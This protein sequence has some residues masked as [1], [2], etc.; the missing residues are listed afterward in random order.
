MFLFLLGGRHLGQI[1]WKNNKIGLN[2]YLLEEGIDY[3]SKVK[4]FNAKHFNKLTNNNQQWYIYSFYFVPCS[5]PQTDHFKWHLI[6]ACIVI[7]I[8]WLE[9][10]FTSIA[11]YVNHKCQVDLTHD[12]RRELSNW[13]WQKTS[14]TLE[15]SS[16]AHLDR[17]HFV[18]SSYSELALEEI[19]VSRA[20]FT[21][22]SHSNGIPTI[23]I[24]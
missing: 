9:D 16:E 14:F 11:I 13:I 2:D 6:N 18:R 5:F 21:F 22:E 24:S 1:V 3:K 23:W 8:E 10:Y 12:S 7:M 17:V 15:K 19:I 4:V 20:L